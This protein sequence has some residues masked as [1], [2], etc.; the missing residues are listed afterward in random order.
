MATAAALLAYP[1]RSELW[2]P[3]CALVML[4]ATLTPYRE[5]V[6]S[7]LAVLLTNLVVHAI[8]G[9]VALWVG[10]GFWATAFFFIPDRLAA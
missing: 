7:C 6:G 4:L 3:S 10:I 1:L 8:A 2:W 9:D 5:L